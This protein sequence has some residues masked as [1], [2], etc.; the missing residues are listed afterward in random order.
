MED[1][2]PALR[3]YVYPFVD[4][5]RAN[6]TVYTGPP[7]NRLLE[8]LQDEFGSMRYYVMF[9]RSRT[10]ELAGLIG[11][12]VPLDWKPKPGARN[13]QEILAGKDSQ[14]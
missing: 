7:Y 9:R 10:M 12:G 1:Q 13:L 14:T 11:V 8:D 2:D 5:Q 3:V 4:E 6:A